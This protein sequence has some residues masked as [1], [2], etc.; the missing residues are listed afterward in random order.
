MNIYDPDRGAPYIQNLNLSIRARTGIRFLMAVSYTGSKGTALYDLMDQNYVKMIDNGF[1]SAFNDTR[2]GRDA[3]LF[4]QMYRDQ[5][6]GH[7]NRRPSRTHRILR[8]ATVYDTRRFAN[9]N[10][11][12][13]ASFLNS[14]TN[15]TGK[16]G[17]LFQRQAA[18]RLVGLQPAVCRQRAVNGNPTNSRY[19]SLEVKVTKRLSHGL[20]NQTT[21]TWSKAMAS[22]AITILSAPATRITAISITVLSYDRPYVISSSGTYSLPFGANRAF[23]HGGPGWFQRV[24]DQWQLGGLMR[25]SSGSPIQFTA[26]E[27]SNVSQRRTTPRT[28]FAPCRPATSP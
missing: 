4:D 22:E 15:I 2:S 20:S 19:H 25:M 12:G 11:G 7:R 26:A 8:V 14:S 23:M 6:P 3:P 17:G 13:V 5:F 27:L 9:G 24:V 16:G 1:L 28:F 21:Y 10:A 18:R